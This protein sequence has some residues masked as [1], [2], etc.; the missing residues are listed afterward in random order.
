MRP[1]EH[2]LESEQTLFLDGESLRL[3]DVVA[4]ARHGRPVALAEKARRRIARCREMVELLLEREE[5]VYGLTTGFGKLRDVPIATEDVAA[6]QKNLIMSHACGVGD[7]FPEDVVRA[8]TLLRINT[9]CRGNSGIRLEV[10]EQFVHLLNDGVYVY[11]PEKGSVGASGDLAPLS[12]LALLLMGHPDARY[13]PRSARREDGRSPERPSF[14][15]F[16]AMPDIDDAEAVERAAAEEG[17]SFRPV[18]LQAKEGLALNNGTQ[19]MTAV[20]CLALRDSQRALRFAEMA[21]AL[22]LEAQRGVRNAYDPRLHG[23]RPQKA[24]PEVA[25]RVMAYCEGS[26][27]LDL[28]LNSAHLYRACRSLEEAEEFLR[29]VPSELGAEGVGEPPPLRHAREELQALRRDVDGLLPAAEGAGGEAG[30]APAGEAG[31]GAPIQVEELAALPPRVQIERL[32]R[33]LR[34]TRKQATD[35]L[36]LLDGRTFPQTES[37]VKARSSLVAAVGQLDAAVPAAPLVQDDY[38]FRCFPQVLACAY[39]AF[40]HVAEV[41]EVELNSVTD[42]PLLFPPDPADD[43]ADGDMDPEAYGAWLRA[44]PERVERCRAGVLGGGNFHGEPVA[45]AVDYLTIA[46]AEVG[47]IAERRVA[48]LVDEHL[49]RGLPAFLIDASGINSGFMIP[50]YT[51]AALVSENKVL[52]HPASVDSIPTSANAEDHVSMGTIAARKSAEV[53]ENV[54]E[55]I[56]IEILTAYQGLKFRLPLQPG[57]ALRRVVDALAAGGVERYDADRVPYPD[58]RRVRRLMKSDALAA[59]LV[60]DPHKK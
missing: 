47:S 45:V 60:E 58:F 33:R 54:L 34:P 25:R 9:L 11:V 35:L 49:S 7:P 40:D 59:C 39:R 27:I 53:V 5:K 19:F 57:R 48:H 55:I 17:W 26:E 44:D 56:A 30:G 28:Y 50:Q 3:D 2:H 46:M 10:V 1:F 29:Q 51:A 14:D 16:R 6:L 13:L 37:A 8:A 41:V 38:S 42:N 15:D 20:A 4:V 23:V 31:V 36:G 18:A 24:Q 21:G 52:A 32:V 12:H 22:S 43:G